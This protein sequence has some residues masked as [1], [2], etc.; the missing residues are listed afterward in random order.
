VTDA[1]AFEQLRATLTRDFLLPLLTGGAVRVREPIG[2]WAGAPL[3]ACTPLLGQDAHAV[4]RALLERARELAWIEESSWPSLWTL[5][6][7]MYDWLYLTDPTLRGPVAG[8][9]ARTTRA[10][11]NDAL[12]LVPPPATRAEALDRHALVGALLELTRTDTSVRNWTTATEHFCGR[13]VPRRLVTF[14]SLRRVRIETV[15]RSIPQ[16]DAQWSNAH[17]EGLLDL[18]ISRS[19]LS[20]LVRGERALAASAVL[21][22]TLSDGRLRT[23][24]ARAWAEG[25]EWAHIQR[26]GVPGTDVRWQPWVELWLDTHA[27]ACVGAAQP[28]PPVLSE[29]QL[30]YAATWVAACEQS[31]APEAAARRAA[32]LREHVSGERLALARQ[33][34]PMVSDPFVARFA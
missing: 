9:A 7:A 17:S 15:E 22:A 5:T 24:V 33:L 34:L 29:A 21:H 2:P 3:A 10:W 23:G 26:L 11:V 20:A 32:Q 13:V 4:E 27:A 18:L 14:P 1:A 25:G 12:T 8:R 28:P 31:V 16:L 30:L 6:I 19:P